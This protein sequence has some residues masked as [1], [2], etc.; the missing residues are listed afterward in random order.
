MSN[1]IE[2]SK[3]NYIP[4]K[5]WHK[6]MTG[7]IFLTFS[8]VIVGLT[9]AFL[10]LLGYYLW[11]LKFGDSKQ[12]TEKFNTH[13]S[14]STDVPLETRPKI[15]EDVNQYIRY[16]NPTLD[17]TN[18]PITIIAFIDFECPFSQESYPIFQQV[19]EKYGPV[20]NVVFKH[21]PLM[22]I[23]PN[24]VQASIAS[25]CAQDQGKFWEY[26]DLLFINKS[27][28]SGSLVKYAKDLN[29]NM[30][31]FQS[32]VETQKNRVNIEQDL[33]DGVDL[34]VRGTPTYIVNQT[35]LEG[36]VSLT[37]WDSII[38]KELQDN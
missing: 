14:F 6:K 31:N 11:N 16:F 15:E 25:T 18:V 33:K 5:P 30:P 17:N 36:S 19:I 23:H 3:D 32:C 27:L 12:I 38:V 10:I 20:V 1:F 4:K 28:D 29:L 13:F 37:S 7:I 8:F 2:L 35:K 21:F 9:L 22:S 34:G 26:Y 24:A